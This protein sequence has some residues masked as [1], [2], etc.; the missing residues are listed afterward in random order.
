MRRFSRLLLTT[1]ACGLSL[2]GGVLPAARA[3]NLLTNGDF[4]A[5]PILGPGQTPVGPGENKGINLNPADPNYTQRIS[6]IVGWKYVEL[7]VPPAF[8]SDLGLSRQSGVTGTQGQYAFNNGWGR[9]I[10]QTV[11]QPAGTTGGYTALASILFGTLANNPGDPGRAGRFYLVAG[12]ADPT[13]LDQFSPGSIILR[14]LFVADANWSASTPDARVSND[15]FTPLSLSYTYAPNDPALGLP[16]TVAFRTE[17]GSSG[18]T[19]WDNA[20]LTVT[21]GVA[22]P[23]PG[24]ALLF[25]AVALPWVC[26][27][28]G[29]RDRA[30]RTAARVAA[31][32][33][34]G[35]LLASPRPAQAQVYMTS[36]FDFG[37]YDYDLTTPTFLN[38]SGLTGDQAGLAF[39]P[40]NTLYVV[41]S[42]APAILRFTASGQY[43]GVFTTEGLSAPRDVAIRAD[44]TVMVLNQRN[45]AVT[46][47]SATGQLLNTVSVGT[48]VREYLTLD[49]AGNAY[50]CN[51]DGD[52]VLR[53]ALGDTQFTRVNTPSLQGA[54]AVAFDAAGRMYVSGTGNSVERFSPTGQSLG[55]FLTGLSLPRDMAF[56]PDGSL[57]V[58]NRVDETLRRYDGNGS[59]IRSLSLPNDF[60]NYIT[61]PVRFTPSGAANAPE[62]GTLGLMIVACAASLAGCV[63]RRAK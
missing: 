15:T 13:N 51:T 2:L 30:T 25:L 54:T 44:G 23:E 62:P 46:L 43:L 18:Y 11:S 55:L 60:S 40:D 28:A 20:S 19:R 14:E 37:F 57:Y 26:F 35:F 38:I 49:Q 8:Y 42:N 41:R 33:L 50:V 34:V 32:G 5:A 61:T 4:E 39:A 27:R 1:T 12:E 24:G 36:S 16:L 52:S 10:S 59:L 17:G 9:L 6:G 45:D 3:Q 29:A 21:P 53:L 58:L 48:G 63:V 31:A 47:Y 7:D 56:G 22:A